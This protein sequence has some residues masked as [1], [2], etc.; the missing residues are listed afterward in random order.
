VGFYQAALRVVRP[1]ESKPRTS[2]QLALAVGPQITTP[3]PVNVVR[4]GS[5]AATITL[6]FQPQ[7]RPGQQVSLLLGTR[8]VLADSIVTATGTLTFVVENAIPGEHLVRLRVDGIESPVVD[9][10]ATPPAFFNHR[11]IIT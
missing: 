3:L 8:E 5:G 1:S 11:I 6:N 9:Y 4:D 10:L 2:N 7:A